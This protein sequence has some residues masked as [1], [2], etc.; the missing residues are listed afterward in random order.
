MKTKDRFQFNVLLNKEEYELVQEL[1]NKYAIN[2]SGCFKLL[3]KQYK[4][5]LDNS[6]INLTIKNDNK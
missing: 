5:Q 3:L 6:S 2:I 4:K 1:K